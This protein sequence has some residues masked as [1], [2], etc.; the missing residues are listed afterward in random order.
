MC[1]KRIC[2][3]YR[4]KTP[5]LYPLRKNISYHFVGSS[6]ASS[7]TK[8]AAEMAVKTMWDACYAHRKIEKVIFICF[9]QTVKDMYDSEI[10]KLPQLLADDASERECFYRSKGSDVISATTPSAPSF[11]L[12]LRYFTAIAVLVPP[13]LAHQEAYRGAYRLAPNFFFSLP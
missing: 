9:S 12:R 5:V 13:M 2:Q 6:L 11:T 3:R 1:A 8:E 4:G 7:F 10:A